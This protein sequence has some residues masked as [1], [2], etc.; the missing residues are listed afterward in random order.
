M[1]QTCKDIQLLV[2]LELTRLKIGEQS[3]LNRRRSS[4]NRMKQNVYTFSIDYLEY[5]GLSQSLIYLIDGN[6]S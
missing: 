2:D 1:K 4:L 6:D 3:F 5:H